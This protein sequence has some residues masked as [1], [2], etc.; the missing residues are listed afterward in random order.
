M[1]GRVVLLVAEEPQL[2][3]LLRVALNRRGARLIECREASDAAEQVEER[4]P[5]CVLLDLRLVKATASDTT[6]LL[7]ERTDAPIIAFSDFAEDEL[8]IAILDAGADDFLTIPFSGEEMLARMRAALRRA[9]RFRVDQPQ[10]SFHAGVLEVDFA[11]REVRVLGKAIHLTPTE[12]KLLGVLIESAGKVV[13]H[14]QL[15]NQVWGPASRD[16]IQYLRVY[17]KQLRRKLEPPAV[18]QY[19]VTEPAIGYRLRLPQGRPR[20]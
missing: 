18:P 2:R 14:E 10:P 17:M 16:Q 15:L 8:K 20:A 19:L 4:R 12:Y 9:L 3:A 5:D 11:A 6:A 13:T 1:L 7:R